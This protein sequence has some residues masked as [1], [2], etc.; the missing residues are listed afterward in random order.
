MHSYQAIIFDMDGVVIDSEP[1]HEQAQRII[2]SQYGLE[3]PEAAFASFKGKTEVDVFTQIADEYAT[4]PID[5]HLLV[6]LKEQAYTA[7]LQDIALFPDVA[8]FIRQAHDRYPLALTTSSV[9]AHQTFVFDKFT[10][11]DYFDVVVTAEDIHRPKPDPEPYEVTVRRLGLT[12][13]VCLVIEDSLNGVR[14]ARGAGCTVAGLTTSFA[15]DDLQRAGAH[16]TI[17]SFTEL[18]AHLDLPL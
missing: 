16:L 9:R 8:P 5:V 17:D 15:A 10:L 18:A 14:S 13:E 12:P 6:R 2:F 4:E 1:L 3:V 7:L 11:D